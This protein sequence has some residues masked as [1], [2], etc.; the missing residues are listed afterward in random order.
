MQSLD[1]LT[2]A[3]PPVAHQETCRVRSQHHG[4]LFESASWLNAI[5]G[6]LRGAE[7]PYPLQARPFFS[8]TSILYV[9]IYDFS[10]GLD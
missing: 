2:I 4:R 8:L 10:L 3:A 7:R 9:Y 6:Y 1:K 5:D